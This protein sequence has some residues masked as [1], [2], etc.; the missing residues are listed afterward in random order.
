MDWNT[1][2]YKGELSRITAAIHKHSVTNISNTIYTLTCF[3]N[4]FKMSHL[5]CGTSLV[6]NSATSLWFIDMQSLEWH[7]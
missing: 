1:L 2:T 7:N 4:I 5:G 6:P 3:K